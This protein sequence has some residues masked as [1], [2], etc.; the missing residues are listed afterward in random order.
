MTLNPLVQMSHAFT[1]IFFIYETKKKQQHLI[2]PS[3]KKHSTFAGVLPLAGGGAPPFFWPA[4]LW[5]STTSRSTGSPSAALNTG[6]KFRPS[7]TQLGTMDSEQWEQVVQRK[8]RQRLK[9]MDG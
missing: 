5:L 4:L 7:I 9:R 6:R 3:K 1:V 8:E 2:H